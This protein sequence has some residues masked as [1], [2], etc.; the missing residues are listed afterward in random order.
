MPEGVRFPVPIYFQG[1][2]AIFIAQQKAQLTT[3]KRSSTGVSPADVIAEVN[4]L[5]TAYPIRRGLG[6]TTDGLSGPIGYAVQ[7][8]WYGFVGLKEPA[9]VIARRLAQIGNVYSVAP[10]RKTPTAG[11]SVAS[12]V[13]KGL[14]EGADTKTIIAVVKAF[15]LKC[16]ARTVA[17][18]RYQL[19]KG[20]SK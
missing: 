17:F 7:A 14:A 12:L 9:R 3:K 4:I 5:G 11:P 10:I 20:Q 1:K 19:K 15:G 16:N 2:H 8:A 6:A 13:R 18:Y